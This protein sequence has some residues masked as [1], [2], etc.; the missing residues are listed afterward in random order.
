MIWSSQNDL[1]VNNDL[2]HHP[3]NRHNFMFAKLTK[4]L[5]TVIYHHSAGGKLSYKSTTP[6]G[7][8]PLAGTLTM[9]LCALDKA[10]TESRPDGLRVI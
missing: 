6:F 1:R 10:K 7:G 2:H 4:P 8:V 3:M 5:V 9:K